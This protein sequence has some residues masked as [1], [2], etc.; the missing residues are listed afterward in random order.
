MVYVAPNQDG[1]KVKFRPRYENFIGGEWVKPAKGQYFE[2]CSDRD[3]SEGAR[4]A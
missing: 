4:T 3:S 1:S 2:N